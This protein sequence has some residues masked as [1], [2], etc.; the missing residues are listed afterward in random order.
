MAKLRNTAISKR[1][2]EALKVEKDTVF[3][4]RELSGF[5]VRVYAAGSKY[6]VIQTRG[7]DG[8]KRVTVGRHGI[9][10]ANQARRRAAL[11]IARI[12][13]GEEAY[14]RADGADAGRW[15]DGGRDRGALSRR[16]CSSALQAEDGGD[17]SSDHREAHPARA[18]RRA[19]GGGRA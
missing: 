12:K 8:P 2:V 10:T 6:Y 4:D 11:I 19:P 15:A 1:T 16:T 7:P 5:G 13:A 14:P 17:V 18:W 3:W 9:I